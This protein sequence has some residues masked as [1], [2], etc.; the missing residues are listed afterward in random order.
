MNKYVVGSGHWAPIIIIVCMKKAEK[1]K[2]ENGTQ[3]KRAESKW[4]RIS[5]I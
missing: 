4:T 1:E 2:T 5:D 3:N